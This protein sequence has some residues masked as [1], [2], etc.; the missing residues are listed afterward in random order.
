MRRNEVAEQA[1]CIGPE[2]LTSVPLASTSEV[3]SDLH[4]GSCQVAVF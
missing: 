1:L 2:L 4:N 3:P